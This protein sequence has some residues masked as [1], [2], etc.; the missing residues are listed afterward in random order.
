MS[1]NALGLNHASESM[2]DTGLDKSLIKQV[3]VISNV[4]TDSHLQCI[5][6]YR[7]GYYSAYK[8][9]SAERSGEHYRRH[10]DLSISLLLRQGSPDKE[11]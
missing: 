10:Y 3:P 6:H 1:I 2:D 5:R 7:E 8:N 11:R 4:H 9:L